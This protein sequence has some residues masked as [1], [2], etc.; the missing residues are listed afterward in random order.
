MGII[1]VSGRKQSG[2]DTVGKIIQWLMNQDGVVTQGDKVFDENTLED[3]VNFINSGDNLEYPE[4]TEWQVKKFA[5]KLKDMVCMLIGCTREQLEDETFKNIE[6]GEEWDRIVNDYGKILL[7]K[8]FPNSKLL[9]QKMTPRLL[10][11]LLGTECGREIIHPS[12]WVNSLMVDYKN[13]AESKG[14]LLKKP[15]YPKIPFPRKSVHPKKSLLAKNL[16]TTDIQDAEEIDPGT[17][18]F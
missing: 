13:K 2:K 18:T 5:D 16:I 12:I 17:F 8:D 15:I 1:G 3:C 9:V 10:M 14:K 11:Q 4:E 6:L 7:P